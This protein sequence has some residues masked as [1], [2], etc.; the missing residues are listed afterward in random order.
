MSSKDLC[1]GTESWLD[2]YLKICS[3][4]QR[5]RAVGIAIEVV[6]SRTQIAVVLC[7]C[8]WYAYVASAVQLWVLP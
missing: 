5:S 7:V 3:D 8:A 4:S 6:E 1:L 2:D